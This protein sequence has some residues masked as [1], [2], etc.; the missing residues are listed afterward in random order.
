MKLEILNEKFPT[1]IQGQATHE[2]ILENT[3][4]KKLEETRQA[5]KADAF[6]EKLKEKKATQEER[7]ASQEERK[8]SQEE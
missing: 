6:L 4:I 7:K 8:P 5:K 2:E 1:L 3:D